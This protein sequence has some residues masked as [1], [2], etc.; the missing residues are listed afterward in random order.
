MNFL[1]LN[2]GWGA[3][4]NAPFPKVEVFKAD[5]KIS[6]TFYLNSFI[7]DD[8]NEEDQGILQFNNCLKYRLGPTNDEGFYSGKCR[9][10]KTGVKWG[11]FYSILESNF[12][13][14]FP[15]DEVTIDKSL[16]DNK[17]LKHYLFYFRDETFEC[18]A[19]DYSFSIKRQHT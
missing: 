18:I 4:P 9:F 7:Y 1:K 6:L 3:E 13:I 11:D 8:V 19:E 16:E 14:D 17:N 12:K 5:S 2:L 15:D 10:S